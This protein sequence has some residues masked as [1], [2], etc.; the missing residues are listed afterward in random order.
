[1]DHIVAFDHVGHVARRQCEQLQQRILVLHQQLRLTGPVRTAPA[2]EVG[3]GK[4]L[5]AA[6]FPLSADDVGARILPWQAFVQQQG[7]RVVQD[8]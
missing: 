4:L 5:T 1:M 8:A 7:E 6:V 2:F 3:H